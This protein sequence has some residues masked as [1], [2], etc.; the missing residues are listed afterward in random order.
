M[1]NRLLFL[2]SVPLILNMLSTIIYSVRCHFI[3]SPCLSYCLRLP[4]GG[5]VNVILTTAVRS[6]LRSIAASKASICLGRK[7]WQISLR[8]SIF[9]ALSVT[10]SA[11]PTAIAD[12]YWSV[13]LLSFGPTVGAHL[14]TA[15]NA[16]LGFLHMQSIFSPSMAPWK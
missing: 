11:V 2:N 12:L 16:T 4:V 14:V 6:R 8:A 7:R 10:T 3:S 13:K 9:S 5:S 15:D 1:R